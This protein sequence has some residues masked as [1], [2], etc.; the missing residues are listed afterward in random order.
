MGKVLRWEMAIFQSALCLAAA[1]IISCGCATEQVQELGEPVLGMSVSN[2]QPLQ[3]ALEAATKSVK[4]LE[5]QPAVEAALKEVDKLKK[6]YKTKL[7]DE[8]KAAEKAKTDYKAALKKASKPLKVLKMQNNIIKH[9][10]AA[11][12]N[13]SVAITSNGELTNS[14]EGTKASEFVGFTPPYFTKA[15]KDDK[16]RF[17]SDTQAQFFNKA[18]GFTMRSFNAEVTSAKDLGKA[19]IALTVECPQSGCATLPR[20]AKIK[21]GGP[22]DDKK[23]F[24]WGCKTEATVFTEAC[25]GCSC[26]DGSG[27]KTFAKVS[28]HHKL[29]K[30]KKNKSCATWFSRVDGAVKE[31]AEAMKAQARSIK[32]KQCMA[33]GSE[34]L[35]SKVGEVPAPEE[36]KKQVESLLTL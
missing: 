1:A 31:F 20:D 11:S 19:G 32:A 6:T 30:G 12:K 28:L 3:A 10:E 33:S 26:K 2:T 16:E 29:V 25:Q 8:K 18:N 22:T 23:G 17:V 9:L 27:F 35:E 36:D 4:L 21:D 13:E 24:K 34:P 15:L 7:A 14:T 5:K